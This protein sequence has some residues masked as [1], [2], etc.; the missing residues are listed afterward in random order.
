MLH[1]LFS[2]FKVNDSSRSSSDWQFLLLQSNQ[3]FT[4]VKCVSEHIAETKLSSSHGS[5]TKN[6]DCYFP[7]GSNSRYAPK[8]AV[9]ALY[10]IFRASHVLFPMRRNQT[11]KLNAI[12]SIS[13]EVHLPLIRRIS[14]TTSNNNAIN[15]R[16]KFVTD[17]ADSEQEISLSLY[18]SEHLSRLSRQTVY[19]NP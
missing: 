8:T 11:P 16:K 1:M 14:A 2:F 7:S 13:V 12:G 6:P 15:H 19:Q 9:F 17:I 5:P 18:Q 4:K 3:R 10:R